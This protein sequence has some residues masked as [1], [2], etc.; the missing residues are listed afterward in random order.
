[1]RS[2]WCGKQECVWDGR[3][4][5]LLSRVRRG[6]PALDVAAPLSADL[7]I[8]LPCFKH[9]TMSTDIAAFHAVLRRAKRVL[10]I[11]GAGLSASSG[12]PTFRGAGGLWRNYE[13]TA[14]ATPQAFARDPGL[15]WLFY[16]YRRHMALGVQPNDGHRA[17]AALAARQ[18]GFLCL[19]QNVDS[20]R[21]CAIRADV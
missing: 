21:T 7:H 10:A 17:L 14:L 1:M 4:S 13:S 9:F 18:P 16:G 19:T 5:C 3:G 8:T 2:Q 20:E 15:V 6:V 12:L 11:C